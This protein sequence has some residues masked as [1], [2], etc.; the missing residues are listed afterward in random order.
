MCEEYRQDSLAS[1]DEGGTTEVKKAF[2]ALHYS[3]CKLSGLGCE[4]NH[5]EGLSSLRNSAE[6]GNMQAQV[7]VYRLHE[8]YGVTAP[9]AP[10]KL[11]GWLIGATIRGSLIAHQDLSELDAQMGY[12]ARKGFLGINYGQM[13]EYIFVKRHD[14]LNTFP[15][16]DAALLQQSL[17]S[18]Q[19]DV[20][21]GDSNVDDP[22]DPA[23]HTLLHYAS[24]LGYT[25]SVKALIEMGADVNKLPEV[26]ETALGYACRCGHAAIA[27]ELLERGANPGITNLY[28]ATPMHYLVYLDDETIE[29]VARRMIDTDRTLVNANCRAFRSDTNYLCERFDQSGTA[30][31][32]A[33]RH[34]RLKVAEILL[35]LGADP[36]RNDI[37]YSFDRKDGL[38]LKISPDKFTPE[39]SPMHL[40][41]CLHRCE[42][43]ELFTQHIRRLPVGANEI[44]AG[45]HELAMKTSKV[46]MM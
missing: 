11:R 17:L 28:G 36:T 37:Q 23:G 15:L 40:A 32:W 2:A 9:I 41:V 29:N 20:D 7:L 1:V 14:L 10:N 42:I 24:A 13:G 31:H 44:P 3:I 39:T 46:E 25:E 33:V 18:G 6:L 34:D 27:V 30:L 4:P 26:G 8:S 12:K 43:L 35:E 45:L 16:Q 38:D 22:V 21:H 5:L 19:E